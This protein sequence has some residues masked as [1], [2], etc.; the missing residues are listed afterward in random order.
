ME[1]IAY[2]VEHVVLQTDPWQLCDLNVGDHLATSA[3]IQV[4]DDRAKAIAAMQAHDPD[5]EPA[6]WTPNPPVEEVRT[7]HLMVA[8]LRFDEQAY[9][10]VQAMI[11]QDK[12]LQAALHDGMVSRQSRL[13]KKVCAAL[14]LDDAQVDYLFARAARMKL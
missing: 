14:D 5:F 3:K 2:R 9:D 8:L 1:H 6:D 10:Q 4:F 7:G 13:V 12:L 11:S